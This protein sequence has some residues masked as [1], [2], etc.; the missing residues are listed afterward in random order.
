MGVF[1]RSP[2]LG[3]GASSGA[4][5]AAGFT[6]NYCSHWTRFY[7]HPAYRDFN[8]RQEGLRYTFPDENE[9]MVFDD[10][11][12]FIGY[13]AFRV[14]DPLTGAQERSE[15]NIRRTHEQIALFSERD[16][17]TYL[18]VLEKYTRHWKSVF[19]RHRFSPPPPWGQ[20]DPLEE[21]LAV[22][23][24]GIEPV[25]QFMTVRQLAYDFF[26]SDELRTLFM[27]A[28]STSTGCF[29]DDQMGLQGLVHVLP[30]TLSIEAA[31]IAVGGS[32]AISDAL[33]SAG[34]RLG[35]RYFTRCEVDR[36]VVEGGRAAGIQ[37]TDGSFVR[38]RV[39]VSGLGVTQ[40]V[41]RLLRDQAVAPRILHRLQNVHYD[42]GQLFWA[43]VAVHE[44]PRYS[45]AAA[46]PGLGAQPRLY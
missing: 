42:R 11:S 35:A 36:V 39:V 16:A 9:G 2:A 6:M 14:V 46:N 25:H 18:D 34:R 24:S 29:P 27:R 32:Q 7:G 43:N 5:P 30:L 28:A 4:G 41:L 40:T 23:D 1:E 17:E 10:G 15:A 22:P 31:A 13:S 3:G 12:S 19:G 33:V 38:A 8:L 37:L 20:P 21:L 26:E 44:L 45:A